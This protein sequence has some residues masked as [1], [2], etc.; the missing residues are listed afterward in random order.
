V[1]RIPLSLLTAI[2]AA[3]LVDGTSNAAQAAG[4]THATPTPSA[5][6]AASPTAEPAS[7]AIPKLEAQLKV[8]P[9]DKDVL[10][11][12]A[13]YYL[14]NNQPEKSQP[15]TQKLISLGA[16]TAQVYYVD[17]LASEAL[18]KGDEAVHSLEQ[19]ST[20]D[21]TN[22]QVLLALTDL[23]VRSNRDADA[24]RIAKRSVA[25]NDKDAR[26]LNNYGIILQHEHK[27]DDAR[28]QFEAAYKLDLKDVT[29]LVL[30]AR[31]YED[32][33]NWESAQQTY[34]RAISVDPTS[35]DAMLGR[36]RMLVEQAGA[37]SRANKS[38]EEH[39]MLDRAMAQYEQL[40][41]FVK[42]DFSKA[43][44]LDEE[45][46]TYAVLKH[47]SQADATFRKAVQSY[48]DIFE[49]HL[50]YGDYLAAQKK[51]SDAVAQ[52]T[53]ALGS[54]REQRDA[55]LRLGNYYLQTG[56]G[57]K[58]VDHFK[59]LDDLTPGDPRPPFLLGQSYMLSKQY[60]MAR[61]SY[62]KSFDVARTP[63]AIAGVAAADVQLKNFKEAA[64][65][66]DQIDKNGHD[67]I[68]SNP[69]VLFVMGQT[70][71]VT[72]Q[73]S[74]ARSAYTEFLAYV[75]NDQKAT[76]DVKKLI[77]DLDHSSAPHPK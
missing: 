43:G 15:L 56:D 67:F 44:V 1:K 62:R 21:P 68:K 37:F 32:Q 54:K 11:K 8:D 65:I 36:A 74:K 69:A 17:G 60:Q 45:A 14:A 73:K 35:S 33:Q 75:K 64:G 63:E 34:D 13:S 16:K 40:R 66:F 58:A 6:P 50:A 48:P 47:D 57:A 76:S 12:L 18:G 52:W 46:H 3:V 19:A 53:I 61:D 77:A 31:T 29:S 49:T 20:L 28:T 51:L 2:L 38:D 42:D 27:Y 23:Y 25:F 24:E 26:V 30:E 55:L 41:N 71:T 9:N 70:Y 72:G 4:K 5:A 39:E 10:I 22:S 7:V 59:R